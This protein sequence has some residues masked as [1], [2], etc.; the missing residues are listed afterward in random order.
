MTRQRKDVHVGA[1][2]EDRPLGERGTQLLEEG[3]GGLTDVGEEDPFTDTR[4]AAI[5][6]RITG[7]PDHGNPTLGQYPSRLDTI[8]VVETDHDGRGL[9]SDRL[10]RPV[11]SHRGS[12]STVVAFKAGGSARMVRETHRGAPPPMRRPHP[13]VD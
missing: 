4:P 9:P 1:G 12:P 5:M 10:S 11:V 7:H 13:E 6:G 2:K 8:H 3:D